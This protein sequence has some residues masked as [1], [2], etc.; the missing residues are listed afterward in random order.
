MPESLVAQASTGTP[1]PTYIMPL[2]ASDWALQI[3]N[4]MLGVGH[5]LVSHV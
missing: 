2:T 1:T 3:N 5:Q 4:T